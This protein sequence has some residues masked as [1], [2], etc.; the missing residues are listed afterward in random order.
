MPKSRAKRKLRKRVERADGRGARRQMS[1]IFLSA[2]VC[3]S[4][5]VCL[6]VCSACLPIDSRLGRRLDGTRGE[7]EGGGR[8]GKG[9]REK[10]S[11]SARTF[12]DATGQ[13][14]AIRYVRCN[15][16]RFDGKRTRALTRLDSTRTTGQGGT[17]RE[18]EKLPAFLLQSVRQS[19]SQSII[20]RQPIQATIQPLC[21]VH[22]LGKSSSPKPQP[23]PRLQSRLKK[24]KP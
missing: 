15:A 12:R 10:K 19:V 6:A 5:S 1:L 2:P 13:C 21:T 11:Q 17:V 20:N 18:R 7:G 14:D 9:E 22:L 8:E 3:L 16:M 24:A 4:V 23:Q